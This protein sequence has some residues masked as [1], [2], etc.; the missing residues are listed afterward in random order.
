MNFFVEL[1]V[2]AY[3]PLRGSS[4][5]PLPRQLRNPALKLLNIRNKD[6]GECFR[7]SILAGLFPHA[8]PRRTETRHYERYFGRLNF[9]RI[10][11]THFRVSAIPRFLALNADLSLTVL[12]LEGKRTFYPVFASR[13]RAARHITLLLLT[14]RRGK[15]HYVLVQDMG[16]LLYRETGHKGRKYFCTFCLNHFGSLSARD[17]HE[18]VCGDFGWQKTSLPEP[19]TRVSFNSR[20]YAK[21]EAHEHL[22]FW[23]LETRTRRVES[24]VAGRTVRKLEHIVAMYCIV[25][26][27][28][29]GEIVIGPLTY[30]AESGVAEHFVTTILALEEQLFVMRREYPLDMTAEQA[31]RHAAATHCDLCLIKS[32]NPGPVRCRPLSLFR[33]WELSLCP[34]WRTRF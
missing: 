28:H 22:L 31:A 18:E 21:T 6:D 17:A 34:L 11:S 19:G 30:S 25:V 13:R 15:N 32:V 12:A 2:V 8:G 7:W 24:V 27:N 23:D 20:L 14:G 9:G 5:M 10:P 26:T 29:L 33:A 3:R 1:G 4:Y 16:S